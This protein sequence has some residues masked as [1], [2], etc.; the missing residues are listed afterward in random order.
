MSELG[1]L[2][3]KPHQEI[4]RNDRNMRKKAE[5]RAKKKK[6]RS[7]TMKKLRIAKRKE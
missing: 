1:V 7:K 6:N 3:F 5:K 4:A 2:I